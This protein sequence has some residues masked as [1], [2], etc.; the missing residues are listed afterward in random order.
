[1]VV[2]LTALY[3]LSFLDRTII[4]F[5]IEPIKADLGLTDTELSLLYGF[6]FALFYTFLGIP[7]ARLADRRTR[8]TIVMVRVA[9]LLG[10][11]CVAVSWPPPP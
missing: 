11:S 6:A 9:L 1:M 7:I 5:L 4:V 2:L 10:F 3:M 8:R